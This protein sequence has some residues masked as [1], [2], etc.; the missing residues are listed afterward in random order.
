MGAPNFAAPQGAAE[1]LRRFQGAPLWSRGFRPFFLSAGVW[2]I[3]AIALWLPIYTGDLRLSSALNPIDWHAHEMIFGYIVA[4]VAGFLLTAIPNWTGRLPVSGAPLAGLAALWVAGRVATFFSAR[5]GE[6]LAAAIDVAFLLAFAALIGREVWSGKSGRNLKVVALVLL[7]AIANAG[8][9]YEDALTGS[10]EYTQRAAL[11]LMVMLILLIGG[12][13]TP[14]FTHNWLARAGEAQRP[15]PFSRADAVMMGFSG[16]ALTAWTLAPDAAWSGG[17]AIAAGL[18]NLWRLSRWR[19]WV[20]RRDAL[21]LILHVGFGLAA[22]G[23]IFAGAHGLSPSFVPYDAGVHVWAIGGAGAMTLAMMTRATLGH[24]GRALVAN[25]ATR[26][27]YALVLAA[28]A[29]RLALAF[30]P[31]HATRWL[32]AAACAWILAF[33]AFLIGYAL[34]LVRR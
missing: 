24:A 26:F 25:R 27:A 3:I 33:V 11:S 2:A 20:V 13:V 9:H 28:L 34:L 21:V 12:R 14:S 1:T 16:L 4:V 5:I 17:L 8:F 18:G 19:G 22:T 15:T 32:H 30:A 31:A 23:F 6:P 10:A 29:A 7:L